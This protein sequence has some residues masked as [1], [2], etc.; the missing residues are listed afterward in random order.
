MASP[1]ANAQSYTYPF[2]PANP[3][4]E[5]RVKDAPA[6]EE[7][8]TPNYLDVQLQ[9]QSYM[10]QRLSNAQEA[11][12]RSWPEYNNQ[13]YL[14]NYQNNEKIANTYIEPKKNKDEVALATGTIE[15]KLNTLLSHI[16]NLN[17][18]PE[19]RAFD[20]NDVPLRELGTAMTDILDK[21]AEHDGGTEGGDQEKRLERQKELIK[22]G[23]VLVQDSWVKKS[24]ARK[25]LQR[26]FDGKFDFDAWNTAWKTYY[27]GP[28]RTTL[29]GPSVYPGDI[30]KYAVEDQ[31][32]MFTIEQLSYDTAKSQWGKFENWQYVRKGMPPTASTQ[33]TNAVGARTIYDGKFRMTPLSENQVEVIKYQDPI[34]DEFQIMINGVMMLPIG[35][36]LSA[37]TPG[38][39]INITK[40][41][42]YQI[43]PQFFY[44]KGFCSSGD[45]LG[46]SRVLDELIRLFVLKTRKS[47]TPP[48]LNL[49]S[50]IISPRVLSPGNITQGIPAGAL[51][52]A[53]S[54]QTQGV[55][56]GEFAVY[57]EILKRIEQTT[58]SPA[59]Q[60]QFGSSNVTATEVIEVQRQA[61]LAL[62]IIVGA[63][64]LLEVKLTY[65]RIPII[66]QN[67]FE[68]IGQIMDGEKATNRY[69]NNTRM[70][71][72]VSEEGGMRRV[73]VSDDL[74]DEPVVRALELMDEK[75]FG[76]P[77]QRIYLSPMQ[78][79]RVNLTWRVVVV[80]KEREGS[81]FEKLMFREV[82]AD[83]MSLYNL[84][85]RPNVAGLESELAKVHGFDRS[86]FFDT[87]GSLPAPELPP[88]VSMGSPASP[89][90]GAGAPVSGSPTASPGMVTQVGVG[91]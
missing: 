49:T 85:A 30:T 76:I 39:R 23:T 82:V 36:P 84:G 81:A 66:L 75:N 73:M 86:R 21:L 9:Y 28:E 20:K 6:P 33:A 80:P 52:P 57:Q 51:V 65:L 42:L 26:K 35:F 88:D 87:S 59:F 1:I 48:M 89:S 45:V 17:L 22:Q 47:I 34:R 3:L 77:S 58:I 2:T 90:S 56:S 41:V 12:D 10:E 27:E 64:T 16:D 44:G 63:C 40:Q 18:T 55:T 38:G 31:P 62:G 67:Y 7:D 8:R 61:R 4:D 60:G 71:D 68:P 83:A 13:T 5:K 69:R 74:P 53:E 11:R 14:E 70:L 54:S 32:Y 72:G 29:Y 50:K 78:L 79:R 91:R 19:V 15:G 25:I 24:R 46:L 37:V 43:N